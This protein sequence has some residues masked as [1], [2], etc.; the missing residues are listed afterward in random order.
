MHFSYKIPSQWFET[1]FRSLGLDVYTQNYSF[2]YPVGILKDQ[3][4]R[5][6]LEQISLWQFFF[7]FFFCLWCTFCQ[8]ENEIGPKPC[9]QKFHGRNVYGI[10]RAPRA[11]STEALVL[12]APYRPPTA[13]GERT[14][15]GIALMLALAKAFRSE[16]SSS[17]YAENFITLLCSECSR[18]AYLTPGPLFACPFSEHTYWAKDIIFLVTEHE[19]VGMQ[20]WLNAYHDSPTKCKQHTRQ[21]K[22]KH[23]LSGYSE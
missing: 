2:S 22:E 20:A 18:R 19:E 16:Y 3:V 23:P 10:L 7:F 14:T 9:F 4:G 21:Q 13:E 12:S 5:F 17:S 6:R 1:K 15:G 11:A 8:R